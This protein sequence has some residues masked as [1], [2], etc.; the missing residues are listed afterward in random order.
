MDDQDGPVIARAI[1][2]SLFKDAE[3]DLKNFCL[4][5]SLDAVVWEMKKC[6]VPIERWATF[7]HIGA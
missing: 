2:T 7:I 5:T 6:G 4:A 3:G 1:Y